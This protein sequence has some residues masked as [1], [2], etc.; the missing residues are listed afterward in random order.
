MAQRAKPCQAPGHGCRAGRHFCR[1]MP[2]D[3]WPQS[4]GARDQTCMS[5]DSYSRKANP[6]SPS[7]ENIWGRGI[8]TFR[9]HSHYLWYLETYVQDA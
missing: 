3:G 2:S 4:L 5:V 9:G 1:L 7:R 8:D 6:L